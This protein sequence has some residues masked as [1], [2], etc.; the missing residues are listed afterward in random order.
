MREL[1]VLL[2]KWLAGRWHAANRIERECFE[3]LL[4]CEDDQLWDWCMGRSIPKDPGLADIVG[5]IRTQAGSSRGR[6]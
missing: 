3:Q 2:E 6:R 4:G 1:D 5:Q